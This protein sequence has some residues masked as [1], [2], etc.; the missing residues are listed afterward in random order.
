MKQQSNYSMRQSDTDHLYDS[1]VRYAINR[2][3]Y[4]TDAVR[5]ALTVDAPLLSSK[6][7]GRLIAFIHSQTGRMANPARWDRIL[8][9]LSDA[10]HSGECVL[11]ADPLDRRILFD[12]AFRYDMTS[13]DPTIPSLWERWLSDY[14]SELY[15]NHWNQLS[16]RDLVWENLIP[17]SEPLGTIQDIGGRVNPSDDRWLTVFRK[18]RDGAEAKR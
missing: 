7:A 6:A 10:Q 2:G 17:L 12:C 5:D 4:A 14:A 8:S 11:H 13:T 9:L 15:R 1:A 16:A 18:L 3:T